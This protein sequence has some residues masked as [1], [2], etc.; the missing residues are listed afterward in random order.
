VDT[1]TFEVDDVTIQLVNG[2][3]LI[4]NGTTDHEPDVTLDLVHLQAALSTAHM[5]RKHEQ[6]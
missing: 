6:S 3:V 4:W 5:L 2:S 1:I